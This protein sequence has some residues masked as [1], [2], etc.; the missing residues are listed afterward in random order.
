MTPCPERSAGS[1]HLAPGND[2]PCAYEL[3]SWTQPASWLPVAGREILPATGPPLRAG[4]VP[5]LPG[6]NGTLVT[7]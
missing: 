4:T 3:S 7:P 6:K 1:H 5:E 2:S